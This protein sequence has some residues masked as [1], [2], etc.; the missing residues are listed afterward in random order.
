MKEIWKDIKGYEGYYQVSNFGRIRSVERKIYNPYNRKNSRYKSI[1]RKPTVDKHGYLEINL[2]K[3]CKSKKHLV[4]RIV[5]EAFIPNPTRYPCINHKDENKQNN[6]VN[7]LEWCTPKYN[8]NYGC[9]N[10]KLSIARTNNMY[11]QKPV[12]CIETKEVFINSRDAER[13][14]GY[15]SRSIRDVCNGKVK[16]LH[17]LH[18]VFI[19]KIPEDN[20]ALDIEKIEAEKYGKTTFTGHIE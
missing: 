1:I 7:N 13:K 12:M 20:G 16:T 5:A 6:S 15:K 9:R 3:N 17:G 19:N 14:T 11:N 2:C 4:H 18:W 8:A 10:K